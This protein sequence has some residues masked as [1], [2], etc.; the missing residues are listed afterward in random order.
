MW[1]VENKFIALVCFCENHIPTDSI[2]HFNKS[3]CDMRGDLVD[4][5][6]GICRGWDGYVEEVA[7]GVDVGL[8]IGF[9][10]VVVI[11]IIIWS[12]LNLKESLLRFIKFKSLYKLILVIV[13]PSRNHHHQI[14]WK[15]SLHIQSKI[16][17]LI[18]LQLIISHSPWLNIIPICLPN[19]QKSRH[20]R[21]LHNE[22]YPHLLHNVKANQEVTIRPRAVVLIPRFNRYLVHHVTLLR[23]K[24]TIILGWQV[25]LHLLVLPVLNRVDE[26]HPKPVVNVHGKRKV[27]IEVVAEFQ[28]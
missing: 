9:A 21:C 16:S 12:D 24:I 3:I 14:R 1:S 18:N 17:Q 22:R 10:G 27:F 6:V 11:R 4:G 5:V 28:V 25:H 2:W 8:A 20:I 23:G 26:D 7:V 19:L 13:H 15:V